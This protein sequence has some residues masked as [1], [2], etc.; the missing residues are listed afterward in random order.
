MNNGTRASA[1][2]HE[3]IFQAAVEEFLEKGFREASMD[4]ISARAGASKR[5]V[6]KHFESKENLFR[7]LI[8]RHWDRF[9]RTL[10]VAY[11]PARD[12]RDQL[13]QMGQAQGALLTSVEVMRTSRLVTSEMLRRPELVEEH[14]QKTDYVAAFEAML[15]D[16][17]EDGKLSVDNPRIAA[18]EFMAL[19]KGKAFWP[20]V[21]GAPVV[22]VDE[23]TQIVKRSVDLIMSRYGQP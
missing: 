1:E 16:A 10:D 14:Q 9:A 13:T 3:Q 17:A 4:S 20:V 12:I 7:E 18:E 21:L 23:M 11:D 5:T 15:R 6:Y 19:I 8:R 2:K 22:T